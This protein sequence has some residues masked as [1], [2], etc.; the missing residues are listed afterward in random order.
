MSE[1]ATEW[2][3][4][5]PLERGPVGCLNCGPKPTTLRMSRELCVGFGQV[6]VT[7]DDETIWAGDDPHVWVRR[8]ERRAADDPDHDWRIHFDAPLWDA[9]Y[10]RHGEREWVLVKKGLG[11]A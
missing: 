3:K 7:R 2:R 1:T 6:W 11:F 8:F 4:L 10:Q 9:T 5:E